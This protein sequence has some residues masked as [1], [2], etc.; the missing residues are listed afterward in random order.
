MKRISAERW[1]RGRRARRIIG[2]RRAAQPMRLRGVGDR[3]E[4]VAGEY[5]GDGV[6]CSQGVL[7]GRGDVASNAA[8]GVS[9]GFATEHAGDLL[10]HLHHANV[11]FG[12]VVVEGGAEVVHEGQRLPAVL[13]EPFEQVPG[14]GLFP[15]PAFFSAGAGDKGFCA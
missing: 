11:P 3:H 6:H 9:A 14:F 15:P 7:A 1:A 13:I 2:E 4:R 8:E 5:A 12:Q 10:L